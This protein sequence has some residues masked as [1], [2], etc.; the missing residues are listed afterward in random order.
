MKEC[1]FM[2]IG[3]FISSMYEKYSKGLLNVNR[4]YQRK[5]VWTL[6]EKKA[7]IDTLLKGYPVPLFLTYCEN[8]NKKDSPMDVI[9]GL[10]RLEAIFAFID[11]EFP[12]EYE[13]KIQYFNKDAIPGLGALVREGKIKQ[14]HPVMD[15][16]VC[17]EFLLYQLPLT[18]ITANSMIVEDVFKRINSTGRKLS[19][20]CLRQAGVTGEFSSMVQEIASKVRGDYTVNNIVPFEKM[21]HISLSNRGLHYGLRVEELFW[22]KQDII[23]DDAI[24]RSKDEEIIANIINC[25]LNDNKTGMS[26]KALNNAYNP[27]SEVYA[28]N[29]ELL[30]NPGRK[31]HIT[32][33]MLDIFDDLQKIFDAEHTTFTDLICGRRDTSNKDLVF[34]VLF[35]A[36]AELRN[37]NYLF[38]DYKKAAGHLKNLARTDL[39]ELIL[40]SDYRWNVT[41]RTHLVERVKSQLKECMTL[42]EATP[43]WNN[44]VMDIL[45]KAK[46]ETQAFDFKIGTHDLHS[47]T[48]TLNKVIEKCVQTLVAIAN[49]NPGSNGYVIIGVADNAEDAADFRSFYD[50]EPLKCGDYFITGIDAEVHRYYNSI[51]DYI[52]K[53]KTV[54][55]NNR[56]LGS[57]VI[58]NILTTAQVM[59]YNDRALLVLC[60]K[61]D[62]PLFFN[63]SAYIRRMNSN[64]EIPVGN[65]NE[66]MAFLS[67]FNTGENSSE[68]N[69]IF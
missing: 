53:V 23:N 14:H 8:P 57:E 11:N 48:S 7:L 4:I 51:D 35:L 3:E 38:E 10:Q 64:H 59:R 34:I 21:K 16:E 29:E 19:P 67:K 26:R 52:T 54:I 40:D 63:S 55:A 37:S 65:S 9:D 39:S 18:V 24:R 58:N 28:K 6:P 15:F 30:A 17:R 27:E 45:K 32:N 41:N 46:V 43:I 49:T 66:F 5:L 36:I 60:L 25:I 61:T 69:S 56:S 22:I 1:Y 31:D 2:I 50:V 42:Q 44:E 68:K 12:V 47:E 62:K 20:Q 33:L 13:G